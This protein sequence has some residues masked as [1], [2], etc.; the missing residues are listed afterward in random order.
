MDR[1]IEVKVRGN[2][3]VKDNSVA[4]VQGE[5]NS[6]YL[7]IEF[8]DGWDGYAKTIM[9][10][11]ATGTETAG[12]VLTTD[13]LEDIADSTRIY[14]TPIP[15]EALTE[16]GEVVFAI[17][18]YINGKRK[19]SAYGKLK[20]KPGEE[21]AV[22]EDVTP[23]QAEQLQ[24]QIEAIVDEVAALVS[25]R[26]AL[27]GMTVTANTLEPGSAA[28]VEKQLIG[29]ALHLIFGI[30]RGAIGPQGDK[31]EQG[32]P[33]AQGIQGIQGIPGYTPQKG[34]D[35]FDGKDGFSPIVEISEIVNGHRV[36]ITDTEGTESFD[37][38]DSNPVVGAGVNNEDNLFTSG[39]SARMSANILYGLNIGGIL[40]AD[41]YRIN[42]VSVKLTAAG[43]VRFGAYSLTESADGTTGVLTLEKLLGEVTLD[44]AGTAELTVE[45]GW[46]ADGCIFL[47]ACA[48]SAII[49]YSEAGGISVTGYPYFD[50]ASYYGNAEGD[51]IS[52]DLGQHTLQ[53]AIGSVNYD[54][55]RYMT[56]EEYALETSTAAKELEARVKKAENDIA[57]LMYEAIDITAFS[58]TPSV[59]EKGST[60]ESVS[61]TWTINRDPETLTFDGTNIDSTLRKTTLTGLAVTEKKTWK[62]QALDE[63]YAS[64]SMSATLSFYNGIY[65]GMAAAPA[66]VDS[67]FIKALSG[68]VISGNA[69]RTVNVTGGE[70]LYFW[71]AYPAALGA[72]KF[73]IGGF[74]YEYEAETV[75]FTND[76]G[77]TENYYVYKSGQPI[78]SSVSVT[79]KGA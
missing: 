33:G 11:N 72:V 64:D 27:E 76:Y 45:G 60:V 28:T 16:W 42:S 32:E 31:G 75:S 50:D 9:W 71:Y 38:M 65:Y 8:D 35:Y 70:G 39:D 21:F 17:D 61:F 67:E 56:V 52:C 13:Q 10:L 1:I 19:K 57:E 43:T 20:V 24:T 47:I 7:R 48:E 58:V 77:V 26:N 15:G 25:E 6:T 40:S 4:G 66:T 14:L 3:L 79:V 53:S 37:V 73:N 69:A 78:L 29:K 49:E 55:I 62:L 51:T 54:A 44:A 41:A 34:V 23:S 2:Y 59:A 68:K 12:R 5:A 46:Y 63:R 30:P 22:L 74:D 18:G 36:T